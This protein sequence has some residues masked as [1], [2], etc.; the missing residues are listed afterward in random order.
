MTG[1]DRGYNR[2]T[3][4]TLNKEGTFIAQRA[5]WRPS[6]STCNQPVIRVFSWAHKR[7]IRHWPSCGLECLTAC[8]SEAAAAA[9]VL[10]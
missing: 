5:P 8:S 4:K 9:R 10:I 7:I 6:A 2:S 3:H 1:L